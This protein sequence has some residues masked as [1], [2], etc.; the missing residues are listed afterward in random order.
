MEYV[1]PGEQM[2]M[3]YLRSP[4]ST[5]ESSALFTL[6]TYRVCAQV[7]RPIKFASTPLL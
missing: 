2:R 6:T 1:M 3:M 5:E 7:L 4:L